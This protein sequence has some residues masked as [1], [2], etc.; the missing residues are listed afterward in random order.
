MSIFDL[1][2]RYA[3]EAEPRFRLFLMSLKI[4]L[5]IEQTDSKI[6]LIRRIA[7]AAKEKATILIAG[8]NKIAGTQIE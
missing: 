2:S 1:K 8:G 3:Y 7:G 6:M 5:N 4:A